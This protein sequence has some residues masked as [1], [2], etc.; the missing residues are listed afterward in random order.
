MQYGIYI[1]QDC[2]PAFLQ[3]LMNVR[4]R[5]V[6]RMKNKNIRMLASQSC[7]VFVPLGTANQQILSDTSC[8]LLAIH[9]AGF[10][11]PKHTESPRG[12]E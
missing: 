8:L 4:E 7:F 2:T 10:V 11:Q 5:A 1:D 3:L 9:L 6:H 12:E